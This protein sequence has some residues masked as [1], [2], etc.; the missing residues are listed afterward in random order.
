MSQVWAQATLGDLLEFSSGKSIAPGGTGDF[1]AYGSNGLI[2]RSPENLF[3]SGVII[4]RVGAYCGS[5][6]LSEGPFWASD[7]TIVAPP[8]SGVMGLRFAYYLLLNARLNAWAGGAAQPLLTQSVLK[9]IAFPMPPPLVQF[10]I[11]SILGV[12][13]DLI[14]VNRRRIALL[15]EMARRLFEEWFIHFRFPGREGVPLV[16]VGEATLPKGW[17]MSRLGD[18]TSVL[19]RGIPPKYDD[20]A[21]T[22]VVNQKCI[23]DQRLS[24][25]PA[26]PQS[27]PAPSEKIVS[28]GD[29]LVNS[30]GLEH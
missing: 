6:A 12:Y 17:M 19:T 20:A 16:S 24:L 27:R 7:N 25:A 1:P 9:P 4:G 5:V 26:R 28:P 23:R 29:V 18:L 15:E 3:S 22:L 21:T 11:A 2:G 30:T 14:E 10:R 8:R 13:D